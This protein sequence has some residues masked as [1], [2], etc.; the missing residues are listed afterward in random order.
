MD[1]TFNKTQNF[2]WAYIPK[3]MQKN[4]HL[5]LPCILLRRVIGTTK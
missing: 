2:S 5:F 3:F 1:I 4:R